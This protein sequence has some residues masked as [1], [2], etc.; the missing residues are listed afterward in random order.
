MTEE[1]KLSRFIL[2]LEGQLADEINALRPTSL[3]D[4]L[5][6]AKAKLASFAS[7]ERKRTFSPSNQ[8]PFRPQKIAFSNRAEGRC[9]TNSAQDRRTGSFVNSRPN[10]SAPKP[11]V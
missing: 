7:G 8:G 5:I 6:C 2:G 11:P 4:A 3:A 9:H 10:N 1:Q